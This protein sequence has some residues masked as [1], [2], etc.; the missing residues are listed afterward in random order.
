[1]LLEVRGLTKYFGGLASVNDLDFHVKRGETMGIIGPN[2][3]GK[4]TVFNLISGALRRAE[5]GYYSK[6]RT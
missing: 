1:M 4:T 6:E 5:A 3:V 2:G